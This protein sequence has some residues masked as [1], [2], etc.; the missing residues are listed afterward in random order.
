MANSLVGAKT[1]APIL[2]VL[3]MLFNKEHPKAAVLPVPVW[4]W[5]IMS[6]PSIAI[7]IALAWI[8]DGFTYP[9]SSIAFIISSFKFKSLNVIFS[10]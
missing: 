8:G 1:K 7:G 5:P 4:A 10:M 3:T 2:P 9:K 6:C